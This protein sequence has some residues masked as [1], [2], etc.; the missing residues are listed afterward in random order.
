MSRKEFR[1]QAVQPTRDEWVAL[2]ADFDDLSYRQFPTYAAEAALSDGAVAEF[3]ALRAGSE[4]AGV[5]SLR[6][7]KVPGLPIGVAYAAHGPLC[8]RRGKYSW[9][10]YA[11]CL[12]ALSRHYVGERRLV[13]R[14]VPPY[15]ASRD[16]DAALETFVRSGYRLRSDLPKRT[17]MLALDSDLSQ[18]RR[19]LNGK[20]RNMLVQSERLPIM[21]VESSNPEDFDVM[22]PMLK[23]LESR[24][25]FRSARDVGFFKRLQR[26]ASPLERLTLHI[27]QIEG[28][29]VS[30][31]LSSFAG[32]TAVLLLAASSE[33][34][35]RT[36]ASH[37]VQWRI[38]E[39][40]LRAGL[41]WY[42]TGGIDPYT[43]PGVYSFKKG[44]NGVE[45]SELGVFERAPHPALAQGVA[46]LESLYRRARALV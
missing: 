35:R 23:E 18:I 10:V 36:R 39:E 7:K 13:L 21:I 5:C 37:R 25:R 41:R 19:S 2:A 31:S 11:D 8:M 12:S 4:I 9:K 30:A 6:V 29:V 15:A 27:A 33:E 3:V 46:F 14:V 43:N 38:V 45:L 42:D 40:A 20:W 44:L 34:G 22:A 26:G 32:D 28:R 24:K 16:H 17:I 1:L